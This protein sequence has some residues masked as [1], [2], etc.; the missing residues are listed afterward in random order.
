VLIVIFKH[1]LAVWNT[2][3]GQAHEL[4]FKLFD[5]LANVSN[6]ATPLQGL[7]FESGPLW[8]PGDPVHYRSQVY[9]YLADRVREL[10]IARKLNLRRS[11]PGWK[12]WW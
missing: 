12:A 10:A 4:R 7:R 1:V 8:A 2:V 9:Q 11:V 6:V 5:M 3:W